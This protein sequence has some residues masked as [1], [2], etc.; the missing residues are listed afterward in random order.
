MGDEERN[1]KIDWVTCCLT[2]CSPAHIQEA[3]SN[4]MHIAGNLPRQRLHRVRQL[5]HLQCTHTPCGARL[6]TCKNSRN[7][8]SKRALTSS[9]SQLDVADDWQTL[10]VRTGQEKASLLGSPGLD[11][12]LH[13]RLPVGMR[14]SWSTPV[15]A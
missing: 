8:V 4:S 3:L 1:T 6:R 15:A 12:V 13:N 11:N 7:I 5:H 9:S 2:G 10:S 14:C